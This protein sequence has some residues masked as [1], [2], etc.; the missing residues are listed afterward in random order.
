M[1]ST[2]F[3]TC[4]SS[5][6]DR[7]DPSLTTEGTPSKQPL[8]K[9]GGD[10]YTYRIS[11]FRR[12]PKLHSAFAWVKVMCVG[13]A[14]VLF[15]YRMR[16]VWNETQ[17]SLLTKQ[18]EEPFL[19]SSPASTITGDRS[20][21]FH[22]NKQVTLQNDEMNRNQ[23]EN[24]AEK[25]QTLALLYP[26]G[27]LGGYR[28]QVMRFIAF[29]VHAKQN[30]MQ[31][32][33]LPSLL[34]ST[35]LYGIGTHIAW[36]PIPFHWLFDVDHWNSFSEHLPTLVKIIPD[37][38]CW[39]KA[40][41][42]QEGN[43]QLLRGMRIEHNRNDT[44][45]KSLTHRY[46]HFYSYKPTDG[47]NGG[48][49]K[50]TDMIIPINH[51]QRAAL[52][53]GTLRPLLNITIPYITGQITMNP[54]KKDF[55]PLT[56]TCRKPHVY[57][58]GTHAGRLWNDYLNFEKQARSSRPQR[59]NSTGAT[60][61]TTTAAAGRSVVPLETD[62]WVYRALRPAAVW[63]RVAEQ[64]VTQHAATGRYM[65]LH[66][67]VELEIMSHACGRSM[68]KNLTRILERVQGLH[69][70]LLSQQS[71]RQQP[72]ISGLFVAVS[73]AGMEVQGT[74]NYL[75][76]QSYADENLQ[77]LNRL[78]QYYH[79]G[80]N[81]HS[82]DPLS[83]DPKHP[84]QLLPVFECGERILQD[85]YACHPDVP[86][87]GSLLQ[88]VVNFYVAVTAHVFVGVKGSSYS[89]DVLTTRYW[90]G[91]GKENYRY[92]LTGIERVENDGLPDPHGTCKR[93]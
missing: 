87:H 2:S 53:Q 89:T 48:I 69:T 19:L 93:R 18:R 65:A 68:D 10:N 57:G 71:S 21:S 62:V 1:C 17:T 75:R 61:S 4:R 3:V 31:Q 15:I 49:T 90:L 47:S 6:S 46:T 79:Q 67:R 37:S 59:T 76:F 73:R 83:F 25:Q 50:K 64:C 45:A 54:R 77:T 42:S 40:T 70:K 35:Q 11:H 72:A 56:E 92:T 52:L 23:T 84:Q 32:L 38:D 86:D 14:F 34:W 81:K 66:A 8:F 44:I 91:K 51:L 55:A 5:Q 26:P 74:K 22:H 88:S 60:T 28:N 29:V 24:T 58:G 80:N 9:Q 12:C 7:N 43:E 85:Y 78:T 16:L 20:S 33:L 30:Q 82:P 13:S 63:R 27:L 41:E 39:V 36:F